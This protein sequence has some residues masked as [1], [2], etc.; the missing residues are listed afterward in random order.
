MD[1]EDLFGQIVRGFADGILVLDA[2]GRIDFANPSA[3]HLL[4]VSP[5]AGRH[6]DDFLDEQGRRESA[7]HLRRATEGELLADEVDTMLVQGDGQPLWVRLRQS[8]RLQD[9]RPAGV[10]LRLSDNDQSK[11]LSDQI[12]SSRAELMRAE[13]IARM[14]SWSWEVATDEVTWSEGLQEL[15]GERTADL[16]SVS[17][18]R[19]QAM[20]H[21]EDHQRHTQAYEGLIS[22]ATPEVDIEIRQLGGEGW[23]WVRM[24]AVG[25]YDDAGRLVRVAGTH[26]DITRARDTD[27][28]LQD[29]VTQNSLMQAVATAAN[30]ATT[31]DEVLA[32]AQH[33]V[34]LHDDWERA[35]AFVPTADGAGVEPHY[36]SQE[37]VVAD[38][39]RAETA[40][41]ERRTAEE[42]Y[43]T[44]RTVWDP[45]HRLTIAFA[46]RLGEEIVAVITI[47]SKPPLYR[48]DMI[49]T[50]VEQAALQLSRV[51]ERERAAQELAATRDRALEASR[52]KSEFLATM[53]HEIRTPLNGVIG[54]NELLQQ[55]PMSTHQQHLVSGIAVS[56]RALLDVI[57]D[58]LDFSKIEAGHLELTVVDLEVREVLE[59]AGSLLA[60]SARTAGVELV[61]SC[62]PEVPQV[63]A[64]DPVRL[65]QVLLN[66]GSNALKFTS[67]GSVGI[68]AS[69]TPSPD[70]GA[71]LRVEVSDTGIGIGPDEQARIFSPFTQADA[72]TTRRFGG[73]GL[74]LAIC[75]EIVAAFGGELGVESEPG[76]GS[77]FWFTAQ[78]GPATGGRTEPAPDPASDPQASEPSPPPDPGA[79]VATVGAPP[80]AGR[81][82]VVED[83]AVNR[84]VARGLLE[85]L[86]FAVELAADGSQ[87]LTM[88]ERGR[89]DVVLMDLQMPVLDGYAATRELRARELGRGTRRLPVVAMTAAAV[90]GERE[91]CLAAGMD[92]FLTK[93]VALA[94][95]AGVLARWVPTIDTG[96]GPPPQVPDDAPTSPHLDLL[97]LEELR[98]LSP[99]DTGFLDRAIDGVLARTPATVAELRRAVAQ[100]QAANLASTAHALKGSALNLGL[101]TVGEQCRALEALGRSGTLTGA[102]AI[103]AELEPT[104]ETS[105]AALRAYR[106]WYQAG[107]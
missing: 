59:Q 8:R 52:H 33:L 67:E 50:M 95:L 71:V 29:L 82:L 87:A 55:T 89:Y 69:S 40:A 53:S 21:P 76:R 107:A 105:L 83:N 56:S 94:T 78:L 101:V 36:V 38:V 44:G 79:V 80:G 64:G 66:L 84:I 46:V 12:A 42:C 37:D 9:G 85:S 99:G 91:R 20:T 13:R 16:V 57:N 70:G 15:Y 103:L 90:T 106:D 41:L 2:T 47:T 96:A 65:N 31:L 23:M 14:G 32:Q 4:G 81:V 102:P 72:T 34:V 97:R 43:A 73:T 93:P 88:L 11:R 45:E 51:A 7:E 26:Q 19:L 39:D 18:E 92:D 58:I 3:E 98:E 5:L 22:G 49:A 62:S 30:E 27:N 24:R 1:H 25:T 75:A 17:Q 60:E 68:R 10:I 28:Q 100:A 77:T 61:V 74:G 35:R 54:L 86:G 104:L 6:V 63:L 48:H